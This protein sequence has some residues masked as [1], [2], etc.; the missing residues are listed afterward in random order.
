MRV[1]MLT[2]TL[3][4][5]AGDMQANFVGEQADAWLAARPGTQITI[6]AP[7]DAAAPL[8]EAEG[9]LTIKRFRYMWPDSVQG[10]AYPAIL[11]NIKRNPLLA[12][13]VP[14]FLAAQMRAAMR[15]LSEQHFDCIYAHWVMPQGV[16]AR[17]VSKRTGVP[18]ILQTHSS[19]LAVFAKAGAPGRGMARAIL[20]DAKLFFCVNS[21]QL[22][23]AL[24]YLPASDHDDFRAKSSVLPMGVANLMPADASVDGPDVGTIGRL[25]R[26]KGLDFLIA[27]TEALKEEGV[28]LH[29]VIAGDGEEKENL[30]ARVDQSDTRF[31]GF[32][33][34]SQKEAFLAS[35]K[36]FAFPAKA[37]DGDVEGL[38]VALLEA[39]MRGQPV[40]A[41]QDTNIEMLPEWG[42]IRNDV[43][44]VPDPSDISA[45]KHGLVDLLA[46]PP[47]SAHAA[48]KAVSRYRWENLIEEY[49]APIETALTPYFRCSLASSPSAVD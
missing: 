16:V 29:L 6:L 2:S 24:A 27:A 1:L 7:H 23:A 17:W 3:P 25:S 30:V 4:R 5:F 20:R 39:L 19:D 22:E 46:R 35:C 28:R 48:A 18:Y 41:T 8:R 38:P 11:P 13:Q 37:H 43:V 12:G 40:L 42:E 26:K 33:S 10:L 15:L 34:G 14:L 32:V 49:C 47:G 31:A 44:F 36:R 9:R 21:G 45:L